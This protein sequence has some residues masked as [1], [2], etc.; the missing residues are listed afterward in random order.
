MITGEKIN[1]RLIRNTEE[2]ELVVNLY[3][4]LNERPEA[5]HTEIK[6]VQ[7]EINKFNENGF[8]TD[9]SGKLL[10]TDK[11]ENIFG[12]ISFNRTTDFELELGYRIFNKENF[13]N[14]IMTESLKLF[15][16]YLFSTKP[17]RRL[18]LQ[19]NENNKASIKLAE[20]CGFK[21]EGVLREAY[22]YRNQFCDFI[23]FGLL[24]NE[25]MR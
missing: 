24:R 21:K 12:E 15:S 13:A 8:W 7:S 4:D 6:S 17:V 25:C 3:N 14:G 18:K 11:N 9:N 19:I 10:I 23:I 16:R 1:L 5:D 2:L 22:F 20:R